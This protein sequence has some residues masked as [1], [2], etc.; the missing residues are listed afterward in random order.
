[1][2]KKNNR[3]E[4][5]RMAALSGAGLGLGRRIPSLSAEGPGAVVAG[6]APDPFPLLSSG[7][8]GSPAFI[9]RRA[10]SWWTNLEDILWPEK[11]IVDRIKR[12]AEN[13]AEAKIDTA[14]NFGFHVR[15]DFSNYFGQLHGYYANVCEELHKYDIKFMEHYSCNH[16]ERPRGEEGLRQL[17]KTQRHHVLLF[18]DPAAAQYAQYE[19]HYFNDLCEVDI[20]D[21]SR[22]YA[23]YYALEVF[24]HNNP[25]FLDMHKKYLQRLMKEVPFDGI[26]I[27]DMCDYAGFT[28]CGCKYCRERLRKDYGHEI[29]PFGDNYFWGDTTLKDKSL[30]GNYENPAFRDWLRMKSDSVADHL[31]MIKS[32]IGALPLMTCCS[33]AGPMVLNSIALNLEKMAP[34]LDFFMLENVG[35][36]IKA[37][38]WM[39]MDAEALYQKDVAEKKGNAPAITIS[40]MI[41]E[42]GGYLGWCLGRFWGVANWSSTLYGRLE[43]DPVDAPEVEDVMT[44]YNNWDI[45]NSDLNDA[46]EKDLVEVRLVTSHYCR[47]NGWRGTDG[48]EQWDRVKAWSSLLV[49]NNIGYRL[50]RSGELSDSKAIGDEHTPL[51]LDGVACLSDSQFSALQSFLSKGGTVWLAGPFGTHDEKGF[52]RKAPLSDELKKSRH[53]NLVVVNTATASDPLKDLIEEGRFR[54]MLR[55]LSGNPLWAARIRFYKEGPA[56]HF[57]NRGLV[58]VPHPTIRESSGLPVL[59]D[60]HSAGGDN[61]LE[62]EFDAGKILFSQLSVR[63]PELGDDRRLVTVRKGKNDRSILQVN[64]EGVETYAVAQQQTI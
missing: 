44:L 23:D 30:W 60:F 4:F 39:I 35:I 41:C 17:Q 63:S 36:N 26:E 33:N 5:I 54:P 57:L 6:V 16:V 49:K 34:Y 21:G 50:L 31:K 1:M 18:H 42:K 43:E 14:I 47:E 8:S 12:R 48:L 22:G 13:F 10:A 29:P 25:G 20:R 15:F 58:A 52:R 56:I 37:V 28:T 27:D 62:Y 32:T 51:I 38:D 59:K 64:L 53:K 40:Y 61:K 46:N 11:K 24:C 55:Q 9:P 7:A 19:G 2:M 45:R 3:R